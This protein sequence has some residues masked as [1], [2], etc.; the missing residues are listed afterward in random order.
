MSAELVLS[1]PAEALAGEL[2]AEFSL[3]LEREELERS[4]TRQ[5]LVGAARA[6][7]LAIERELRRRQWKNKSAHLPSCLVNRF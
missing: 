2:A 6:E 5:V 3:R 7:L 1:A 4:L